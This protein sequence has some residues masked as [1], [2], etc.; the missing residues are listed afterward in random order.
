MVKLSD[1]LVDK[2]LHGLGTDWLDVIP[3]PVCFS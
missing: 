1:L 3:S 2:S